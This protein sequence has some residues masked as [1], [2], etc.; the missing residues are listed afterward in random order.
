MR[1]RAQTIHRWATAMLV[2][3]ALPLAISGC[4]N[5]QGTGP[6]AETATASTES[7]KDD[8]PGE[9]ESSSTSPSDDATTD[10]SG[11]DVDASID[12]KSAKAEIAP[13]TSNAPTGDSVTTDESENATGIWVPTDVHVKRDIGNQGNWASKDTTYEIDGQGN[14]RSVHIAEDGSASDAQGM[15]EI[16][17]TSDD[18][19][20]VTSIVTTDLDGLSSPKHVSFSYER[21]DQGRIKGIEATKDSF[22][23]SY[24]LSYDDGNTLREVSGDGLTLS[25]D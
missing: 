2:A 4:G 5:T 3:G 1:D 16:A 23:E 8:M 12:A 18:D 22:I 7:I 6:T 20:F 9:Q 24:S 13:A 21:D 14:L 19:G 10:G 25:F 17:V 11:T 15:D